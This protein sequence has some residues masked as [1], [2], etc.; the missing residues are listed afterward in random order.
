MKVMR[1]SEP[2]YQTY[3]QSLGTFLTTSALLTSFIFTALTL[4]LIQLEDVT[5]PVSQAT[6]LVLQIAFILSEFT[7]GVI[8]VRINFLTIQAVASKVRPPSTPGWR[9]GNL[10]LHSS[11]SLMGVSIVLMFFYRGLLYLGLISTVLAGLS[12]LVFLIYVMKP[13]LKA[14]REF[15]QQKGRA[16]SSS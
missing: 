2:D 5:T 7:L 3:L 13:F 12:Y 11:V 16:E 15:Y 6:L 10:L 1:M 9:F 4:V 14:V 8:Q